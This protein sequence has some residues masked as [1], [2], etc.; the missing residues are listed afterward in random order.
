[1]WILKKQ[2]ERKTFFSFPLCRLHYISV[3]DDCEYACRRVRSSLRA[4]T[5][6]IFNILLFYTVWDSADVFLEINR[7]KNC[8]RSICYFNNEPRAR[9]GVTVKVNRFWFLVRIRTS[10]YSRIIICVWYTYSRRQFVHEN[11]LNI[12]ILCCALSPS[13]TVV[14]TCA[15]NEHYIIL[16]N[17]LKYN[18]YYGYLLLYCILD[19]KGPVCSAAAPGWSRVTHWKSR[20][21]CQRCSDLF[22]N[23]DVPI[24]DNL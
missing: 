1:M 20:S 10:K 22:L 17:K 9:R 4:C 14:D 6:C 16:C 21:H 11:V 5:V 18:I 13:Y 24:T 19:E 3:R 7:R 8:V 2:C 23:N 12:I 15:A